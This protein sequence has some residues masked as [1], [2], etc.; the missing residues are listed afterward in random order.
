MVAWPT[1]T[2]VL[3]TETAVPPSRA[4][5]H[6]VNLAAMN[7]YSFSKCAR[8]LQ[9]LGEMGI[10]DSTLVLMASDMGDPAAH[11]TQNAPY[12]LGGGLNGK[13]KM[14]RNLTLAGDCPPNKYY[15]GDTEK[16]LMPNGRLLAS[17]V[18][19]FGVE[20]AGYGNQTDPKLAQ[21]TLSELM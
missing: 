11:S 16:T 17:I 15:C 12:V 8:L 9:R 6:W 2:R 20:A 3:T 21:G 4:I 19:A 1:P 14:G 13:I 10:L 7:K 18:N 5:R